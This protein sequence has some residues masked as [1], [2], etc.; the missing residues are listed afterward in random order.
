MVR[1]NTIGLSSRLGM[2]S[3]FAVLIT[4]GVNGGLYDG[5]GRLAGVAGRRLGSRNIDFVG[6]VDLFSSFLNSNIL[7]A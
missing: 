4:P 5:M 6:T 7:V 3:A 2:Y 1:V